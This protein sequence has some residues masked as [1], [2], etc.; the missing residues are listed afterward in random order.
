MWWEWVLREVVL[1]VEERDSGIS[2]MGI[3]MMKSRKYI[4][5]RMKFNSKGSNSMYCFIHEQFIDSCIF[6]SIHSSAVCCLMSLLTF[7]LFLIV[8]TFGAIDYGNPRSVNNFHSSL[9]AWIQPIT[10][11]PG[12]LPDYFANICAPYIFY[13][14]PFLKIWMFFEQRLT[15]AIQRKT[16]K[17]KLGFLDKSL[18]RLELLDGHPFVEII[19]IQRRWSVLF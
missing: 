13:V 12:N 15:L 10:G 19:K 18:I 3:K 1:S 6:F 14:W 4:C 16:N 8:K 9:L 7:A 5:S 17:L 2:K 11:I